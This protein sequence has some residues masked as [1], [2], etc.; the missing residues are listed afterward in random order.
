[1]PKNKK[2]IKF[3]DYIIEPQYVYLDAFSSSRQNYY[4]KGAPI[5]N[6]SLRS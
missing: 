2:K 4:H 3:K 5:E 1:M 6:K